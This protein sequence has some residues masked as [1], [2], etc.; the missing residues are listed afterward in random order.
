MTFPTTI[1]YNA[2]L[3]LLLNLLTAAAKPLNTFMAT[4]EPYVLICAK[5]KLVFFLF[6]ETTI[7]FSFL[8]EARRAKILALI[9]LVFKIAA[10]YAPVPS[11]SGD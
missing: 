5:K 6:L 11:L 9:Y 2:G 3:D 8:Y 10:L 7:V 4:T 1:D